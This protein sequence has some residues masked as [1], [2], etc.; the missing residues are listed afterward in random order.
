MIFSNTALF[1]IIGTTYG[2]NGQSTFALPDLRGRVAISE[3]QR[4]G[5]S[6]YDLGQTGGE[7]AVTLNSTQIPPHT[8]SVNCNGTQGAQFQ[9]G[10][11]ADP[12]GSFPATQSAGSGIYQTTATGGAIMNPQ[13][14]GI[15]GG[16]LG[17]EN[18]Q[19]Y[20]VLNYI[21]CLQGVFPPRT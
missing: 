11:K 4:P 12:A 21:I 1:S 14:V 15:G 9:H 13:M 17:H 5:L 10:T 16:G 19:P 8:H 2:G 6:I 20:L 3:G 7:E 18:H